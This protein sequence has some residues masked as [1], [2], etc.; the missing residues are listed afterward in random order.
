MRLNERGHA[1]RLAAWRH[2]AWRDIRRP[3]FIGIA[4]S[5]AIAAAAADSPRR[6][7]WPD[8]LAA[9]ASAPAVVRPAV[10]ILLDIAPKAPTPGR[11]A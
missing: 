4:A 6:R 3:L 1:P 5:H 7:S 11:G 10:R 2:R 8:A 9:E